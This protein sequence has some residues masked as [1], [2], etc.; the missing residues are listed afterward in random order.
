MRTCLLCFIAVAAGFDIAVE[1]RAPTER[2]GVAQ[3][4]MDSASGT[5]AIH[6]VDQAL[7]LQPGDF[8]L[9]LGP[10]SGWALR[11]ILKHRPARVHAVEVSKVFRDTINEDATLQQAQTDG[12]LT[13]VG[14][15]AVKLDLD[16]ASVDKIFGFNVVYFLDPLT[17]YLK[18]LLRVMKEGA[19]LV[20]GVKTAAQN[21]DATGK[22][23]VNTNWVDIKRKMQEAGF[24]NVVV[25][26]QEVLDVST[27]LEYTPIVGHKATTLKEEV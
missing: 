24:V 23:Y 27:G 20:W 19:K 11:E 16:D 26:D 1:M 13:V 8:V 14:D 4:I 2:G 22:I 17:A 25:M 10:G 12:L 15:D 18:E 5:D 6:A 9:E 21:I 7:A 3:N